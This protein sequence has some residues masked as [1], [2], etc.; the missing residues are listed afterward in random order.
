VKKKKSKTTSSTTPS[1]VEVTPT[2]A[3]LFLT[4]NYNR[5]QYQNGNFNYIKQLESKASADLDPV[6]QNIKNNGDASWRKVSNG[7]QEYWVS[8]GN[9]GCV[10]SYTDPTAVQTH[11]QTG[12]DP[13]YLKSVQFGTYSESAMIAGIHTYNLGLTTMVVES[14]LAMIIAKTLSSFIAEGLDFVVSAFTTELGL[15][16]AEIGL[17]LTFVCPEVVLPLV[18]T[19]IVFA[20]AFIGLSYLWDW[21]S[22]HYTLRCQIFNGDPN[23]E[24]GVSKQ[25]MG[26]AV[27]SGHDDGKLSFNLPKTVSPGSVQFPP[28]FSGPGITS[29]DSACYYGEVIWK[30]DN[31][32]LEGLSYAIRVDFN[33]NQN[34]QGFCH[35]FDC[36]RFSDNQLA[37][38]NGAMDPKQYFQQVDK[39]NQWQKNPLNGSITS[40]NGTVVKYSCD[41][42][43]GNKDNLYNIILFINPTTNSSNL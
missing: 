36:P 30:N 4:T 22:R 38:S 15:A 24:W 26:N 9:K 25:Y 43:S 35:A 23:Y 13:K 37:I 27:I 20:I 34:G 8:W 1:T 16:A 40:T 2:S 29:L 32:I 12:S 41:G 5:Q 7:G 17:E 21:I 42:L 11:N 31:T 19:C 39:N 33:Y 14:V 28:G 18:A 3:P 6:F 10:W